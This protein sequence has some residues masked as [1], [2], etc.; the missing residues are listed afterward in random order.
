VADNISALDFIP[1]FSNHGNPVTIT[2]E[3]VSGHVNISD[4]TYECGFAIIKNVIFENGVTFANVNLGIGLKFEECTFKKYLS[5]ANT[6]ASGFDESF[7]PSSYSLIIDKCSIP[8]LLI[9]QKSFLE[10]GIKICNESQIGECRIDNLIINSSGILIDD[11]S[12]NERLMLSNSKIHDG[13]FRIHESTLKAS[14]WLTNFSANTI[15]FT[16]SEIKKHINITGGRCTAGIAF[17]DGIFSDDVII[18][19]VEIN[20]NVTVKGSELKKSLQIILNDGEISRL[21][22][23][24]ISDA[25]FGNGFLLNGKNKK[26][27]NLLIT[28]SPNLTG[29]IQLKSCLFIEAKLTED[30]HKG[31]ILFKNCEFQ[32]VIFEHFL[33]YGNVTFSTCKAIPETASEFLISDSNLGKTQLFN[34]LFDTFT[35]VNILD[36]QISEI[37]TTGVTWFEDKNL[38]VESESKSDSSRKKREIYRQ[39]KQASEKQGD[40]IQALE[41]QATELKAFK[42]YIKLKD[43]F[44]KNDR[45]ILWLSQTNN[46]GLN[47]WK[48]LF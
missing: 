35:K 43:K 22:E 39:L 21:E 18:N 5:I 32:K 11:S 33:N 28:A 42:E 12:L 9:T 13:I 41:F 46:F 40:K 34:F 19:G 1:L 10:R 38:N 44:Y 8:V 4:Y 47:W 48:P 3:V 16:S 31:N 2:K 7:E 14:I 26:I 27:K 25:K 37:T 29:T 6:T 45:M 23:I 30:N 36:S 17:N 20:K 15:A 24:H